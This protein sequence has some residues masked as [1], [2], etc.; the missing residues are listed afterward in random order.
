MF[1]G[2]DIS[3][4]SISMAV[5]MSFWTFIMSQVDNSGSLEMHEF[6]GS[7]INCV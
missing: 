5:K 1:A 4:S 6:P 2:I 3:Y 7:L